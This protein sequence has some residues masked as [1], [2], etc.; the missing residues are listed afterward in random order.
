MCEETL[1][2]KVLIPLILGCL[3][4]KR[5]T[6]EEAEAWHIWK[7]P[8]TCKKIIEK[9]KTTLD[10]LEK[11]VR[12]MGHELHSFAMTQDLALTKCHSRL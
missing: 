6:P 1:Q 10:A 3:E 12:V 8:G 2:S 7:R 9:P 4:E 11:N 5:V